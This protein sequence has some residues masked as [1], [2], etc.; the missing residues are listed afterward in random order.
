MI[1]KGNEFYDKV[2]PFFQKRYKGK[3]EIR[4]TKDT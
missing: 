4:S 1:V 3:L 2:H